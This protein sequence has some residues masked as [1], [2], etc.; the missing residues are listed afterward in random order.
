ML[1]KFQSCHLTT[2][3]TQAYESAPASSCVLRHGS[4][5]LGKR[6]RYRLRTP[7]LPI[8]CWPCQTWPRPLRRACRAR[9]HPAGRLSPGIL[10]DDFTVTAVFHEH[11]GHDFPAVAS[12]LESSER[13]ADLVQP[14]GRRRRAHGADMMLWCLRQ[15]QTGLLHHSIKLVVDRLYA[16]QKCEC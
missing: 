12:N 16:Y 13:G 8:Q 7:A 10:S 2:G 11:A 1:T 3:C 9:A 6:R 4:Q 14:T 5:G 15:Q